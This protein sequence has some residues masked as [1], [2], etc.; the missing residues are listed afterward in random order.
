MRLSAFHPL[1]ALVY[2]AAVLAVLLFPS[3]W[4]MLGSGSV[5]VLCHNS[6]L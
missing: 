5:P 4:Y 2:F 3:R 6:K 1:T